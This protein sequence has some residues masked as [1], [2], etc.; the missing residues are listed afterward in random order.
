MST[1]TD[2]TDTYLTPEWASHRH[3]HADCGCGDR[4]SCEPPRA[5]E[6]NRFFPRKLMEVRHWQAEQDYHRRS[7]ELVT[8]LGLGAGV[9]CGLE[10]QEL[11]SGTLQIEHGVGV[12]GHGRIV[13]VPR[14]LEVDPA[15]LTDCCGRPAEQADA[16]AFVT[17]SLCFHECGTDLVPMPPESCSDDARCVPAMVRE[18]YAVSVTLEAAGRAGLPAAVCEAVF[19]HDD[20]ESEPDHDDRRL[21][22]DRL[23]PR[24]CDC[25]ERCI[26]L[27][28]VA[29]G[30]VQ[31]ER[32][33]TTVRTVIRSN[34]QL[35]D[36]ILCLAERMD[37]CCGRRPPVVAPRVSALWPWPDAQGQALSEF[38][39]LHRLEVAFD[40]DIGEQGLDDP[41]AWLGVWLLGSKGARRLP[42]HRAA[43]P[44]GHVTVPSGGDGAAYEVEVKSS[45]LRGDTCVV[46]MVRSVSPGP[47]RSAGPDQLA[48]DAELVGTG[49]TA[50]ERDALWAMAPAAVDASLG[51]LL[52]DALV[53]PSVFLPSGDGGAGGELHVAYRRVVKVTPPPRLLTVWPPGASAYGE[54]DELAED[55]KSYLERPRIELTVSRALAD[56][57]V[58]SPDAWLRV[59][60]AT[61]D[62]D[63]LYGLEQIPLVDSAVEDVGDGTVRLIFT[64]RPPE[65]RFSRGVFLAQLR[66]TPPLGPES[67]LGKGAPK[68]LLDGDFAGTS[69]DSQ[70]LFDVWSGGAFTNRLPAFT[71]APTTGQQL[72]DGSEGGLTHWGF[73]VLQP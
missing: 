21:L 22:L 48:L 20:E 50:A 5:L 68:V 33:D 41:D 24:R 15:R 61:Q 53:E 17:V 18:A 2:T 44:L 51:P 65:S 37:E 39:E 43:G 71:T 57:A 69:L 31:G 64:M 58:A 60:V 42:V 27:A 34:R 29:L 4:C 56:A 70:T 35:L 30:R 19:G 14:D 52:A 49:L 36:L 55:W 54:D 26:P 45:Q 67:P 72:F 32:L 46:V 16:D 66:S 28:T 9:L 10:V 6:R 47:I 23:D 11:P 62:G 8:R 63:F 40:R 12:D 1:T 38:A 73:T 13:V 59:W 7:R 3:P 25:T